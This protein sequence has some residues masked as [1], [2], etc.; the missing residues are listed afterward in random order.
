MTS[1]NKNGSW[2]ASPY[3][4]LTPDGMMMTEA[5]DDG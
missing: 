3:L 5:D 1:A 4:H 2:M